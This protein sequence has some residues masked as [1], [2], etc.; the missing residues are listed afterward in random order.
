MKRYKLRPTWRPDGWRA[1]DGAVA[2]V[3]TGRVVAER[4]GGARV[5]AIQKLIEQLEL[6][7]DRHGDLP[8]GGECEIGVRVTVYDVDGRDVE[9]RW[10]PLGAVG[11]YLEVV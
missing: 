9:S 10:P 6:V 8:V 11:V 4:S 2:T 5:V 3:A 1:V 7:K